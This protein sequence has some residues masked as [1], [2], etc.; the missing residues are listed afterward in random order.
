MENNHTHSTQSITLLPI[1]VIH[2]PFP[3][4]QG[5]PIQP[6]AARDIPGTATI[7]PEYIDGLADLDGFSHII[8]LYHLHQ[9]STTRLRVTPFLDT[10]ERGVF[11]TRAPV[12]P[13]HLGLSVVRLQKIQDGVLHILDVDMLDGTPLVDIKPYVQMFEP[14][15]AFRQGWLDNYRDEMPDASADERFNSSGG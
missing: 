5:T 3:E 4:P 6:T 1:G 2:T 7:Y 12:R 11:A 15:Q 13:N 10:V 8:L 14:G 9:V